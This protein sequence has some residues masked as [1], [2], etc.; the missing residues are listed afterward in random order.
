MR[1]RV[2]TRTHGAWKESDRVTVGEADGWFWYP[3]TGSGAVCA[4]GVR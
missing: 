2:F 3:I 1:L 4:F